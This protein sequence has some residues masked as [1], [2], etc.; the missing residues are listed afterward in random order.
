[1]IMIGKHLAER[2][3]QPLRRIPN[4]LE[5]GGVR[6]N[7]EYCIPGGHRERVAAISRT[8]RSHDHALCRMLGCKARAERKASANTF[9][10]RHNVR[11]NPVVFV[12]IEFARSRHT[13][14]DLIEDEHQALFVAYFAQ[15]RHEFLTG[16]TDATL[17]L[18]WFDEK[19]SR[20]IVDE[21]QR[22]FKIVE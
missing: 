17:A 7:I 15:A 2:S 3:T 6:D 20:I 11:D 9:G 21:C 1:M 5:K 8:M 19:T 18:N 16:R 13:A 4:L 14:L 22:C 10:R 12:R